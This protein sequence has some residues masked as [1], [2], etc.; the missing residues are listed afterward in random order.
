MP[1]WRSILVLAVSAGLLGCDHATKV[2]AEQQLGS[3]RVVTLVPRVLELRYARN[4][5]VAFSALSGWE[6]PHKG[7]ILLA[8]SVAVLLGAV[9]M[10]IRH[11]RRAERWGL[12]DAGFGFVLAGALGNLIDRIAHGYVIDFIHLAHW[13]IFNVADACIVVGLIA[14]GLSRSRPSGGRASRGKA[15]AAPA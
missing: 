14:L 2:V 9:A 10:W 4:D 13:P 12:A 11:R 8:V 5:D 6:I 3:G 7:A 15:R 1:N